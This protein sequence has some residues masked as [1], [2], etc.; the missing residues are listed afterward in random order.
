GGRFFDAIREKQGLAYTVYTANSF[1]TKGGAVYTYTAFSPE[2]ETKVRESL[3]AEIQ[4][5]RNA[6]V[7][8][9]EVKKAVA[10]SVG[11]HEIGLQ[12][13]VST[14]LEYARSIYSGAGVQG[15]ENY[16]T[17]IRKITPD[18]V[19]RVAGQ[20]LDPQKLKIAVVRGAN[21]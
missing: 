21:K 12:T 11:E 16:S 14:V 9:D 4:R 1:L 19:K 17:L 5:L 7:T 13:H 3:E 10:Y 6:G 18:D 2:N 8:A 15:I 20:Y